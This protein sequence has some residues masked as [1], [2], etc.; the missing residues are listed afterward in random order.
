MTGSIQIKSGRANYYAILN[1]YDSNGKRKLKWI[2]TGIPV[3]GNNKRKANAKLKELLVEYSDNHIDIIKDDYFT[4]FMEQWLE[5]RVNTKAIALTTYDGYKMIFD[6]HIAPYF[7]ALKLKVKALTP[8]HL[9]KYVNVK[10][11]DLSPNSVIKHLHNISKCLDTAVRQNLIAYNPAKRMDWPQK[12]RF[13]GAKC[14]T[15]LQIEQLLT[16][17]KGDVLEA[18]IL[19]GILYGFRRSEIL[20]LKWDAIDMDSNILTIRHTVTRVN[21]VLHKSDR[22]KTKSSY[23]NMP[24]PI[25]IKRSLE[26]VMQTQKQ[27]KLMQPNDY[28][29]EGYVFTRADGQLILPKLC[30]Q[31]FHP[32]PGA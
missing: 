9:E 14:L 28:V 2:D 3:K 11:K 10:M 32:T 31:A 27:D 30:I 8:A 21:K 13:T 20:G 23:G 1:A 25:I 15:P 17:A 29:D 4:D 26:S 24:I 12:V 7:R 18:I 16:A 6:T 22:T 19:F 5:T